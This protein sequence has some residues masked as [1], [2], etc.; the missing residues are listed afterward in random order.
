MFYLKKQ[1]RFGRMAARTGGLREPASLGGRRP[2]FASGVGRPGSTGAG[3]MAEVFCVLPQNRFSGFC[4]R[5]SSLT[6]P[7]VTEG[8]FRLSGCHSRTGRD[9]GCACSVSRVPAV[10]G[11]SSSLRRHLIL[12]SSVSAVTTSGHELLDLRCKS[13]VTGLSSVAPALGGDWRGGIPR[14]FSAFAPAVSFMG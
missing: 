14:P 11:R 1:R 4:F 13:W 5:F 9:T 6:A 7:A 10:A 2:R 8:E 12:G 3:R